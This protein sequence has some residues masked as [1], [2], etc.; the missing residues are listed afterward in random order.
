MFVILLFL[1][2][3]LNTIQCKGIKFV[4]I[5]IYQNFS[6]FLDKNV[7]YTIKCVLHSFFPSQQR[8]FGP[9]RPIVS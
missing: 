9:A 5:S 2:P 1:I 3:V 6:L 7:M 4:N 8:N